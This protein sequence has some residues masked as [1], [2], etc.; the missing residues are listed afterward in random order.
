MLSLYI[1]IPFCPTRCHYCSFSVVTD[2][3]LYERY[4]EELLKEVEKTCVFLEKNKRS[5]HT[6][7]FGGGTPSTLKIRDVERILVRTG[8]ACINE[9][10]FELNPEHVTKEYLTELKKLGITRVSLGVQTLSEEGLKKAG[11]NHSKEQAIQSLELLQESSLPFNVD[12]I[13]GLPN[14]HASQTLEDLKTILT[15]NP[16]HVSLYFLSIESGTPFQNVPQSQ[17]PME[18]E[19]LHVYENIKETLEA[20]GFGHYEISNWAKPRFESQHNLLYWRGQ[21]YIGVGLGASSFFYQQR[22]RNIQ[23]MQ[24]YLNAQDKK[25]PVSVEQLSQKDLAE[26][27]LMSA[28]RLQEGVDLEKVKEFLTTKESENLEKNIQ[29][30]LAQGLVQIKHNALT[31]PEEHRLL[32]NF[33]LSKLV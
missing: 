18:D 28:S 12:L 7:Y 33:I 21:E 29:N 20:E 3:T 15:F 5:I 30:L 13:L 26:T 2:Q 19:T 16:S 10:S 11:R 23:N 9:I 14:I 24:L 17:F 27:Y 4:I 6:I 22:W 1:H 25:L 32:Q 8:S 31:I